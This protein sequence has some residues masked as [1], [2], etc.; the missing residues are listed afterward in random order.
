ML[1]PYV[2]GAAG[3]TTR[4]EDTFT[5][6]D[7]TNNSG[8][9]PS[10]INLPGN[11]WVLATN[12]STI[13]GNVATFTGVPV[14]AHIETGLSDCVISANVTSGST[15]TRSPRIYFRSTG[16]VGAI[17]HAS[18]NL[19]YAEGKPAT[20]WKLVEV[21]AG[22]ATTVATAGSVAASTAYAVE[23]RLSGTSIEV[24]V[25]GVLT[26]SH[27]SSVHQAETKHGF[28]CDAVLAVTVDNWKLVA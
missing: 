22:V 18:T 25:D 5:A 8:R 13:V 2:F 23:V 1:N 28:G 26:I 20:G 15:I 10:P 14:V 12:S 7:G 6:T 16:N 24:W 9:A 3:P 11:S 19:W 4:I 17:T 21:T 27:T